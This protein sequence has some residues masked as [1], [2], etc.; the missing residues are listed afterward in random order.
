M[1]DKLFFEVL[2]SVLAVLVLVVPPCLIMR[3]K[4]GNKHLR[5]LLY[6]L[7]VVWGCRFAVGIQADFHE[8]K[9]TVAETLFDSL[10][11]AIQTFGMDD[12]YTLYTVA[13]KEYLL[14]GGFP[15]LASVYGIVM[16]VL[17]IFAPIL[18]GA[19]LLDILLGVLPELRLRFSSRRH[20]FVFSE[21]NDESITLAEDI[22][23][24]QNYRNLI[25]MGRFD[26]KPAIL[27][28]D[29]YCDDDSESSAELHSRAG[30]IGA[31]CV[32]KDLLHI[33]LKRSKSVNYFLIDVDAHANI[34]TLS[35]LLEG[36]EDGTR[37]W[38]VDPSR[39]EP[40]SRIFVF[41]QDDSG[42]ALIKRICEDHKAAA[43]QILIRQVPDQMNA[44][45][46]LMYEVP[47][48]LPL[49]FKSGDQKR[50]LHI[51]I[52]GSGPLAEETFKAA[53]WCGQMA[54][55][56]V[57]M[58]VLDRNASAMEQRVRDIYPE[59][60]ESCRS[61][62]P[63]LRVRPFDE[64]G[65]YNPPYFETAEFLDMAGMDCVSGYPAAVLENTDYY[66]V[67]LET[68]EQNLL[69]ANQLKLHAARRAMD[70]GSPV[71]PV[72]APAVE[73]QRLARAAQ[74]LK[75]G[76]YEPYFVPF[77]SLES[78]YSCKNVFLTSF[79]EQTVSIKSIYRKENQK[80]DQDDGYTNQ[81]S[82]ARAVHAPYKL[83]GL[84]L[85]RQVDL[86]KDI[87]LRY[88]VE[89][90]V[91]LTPEQEHQFAWVEHRRWNAFIRSQGFICPT[92]EQYDRFFA[93]WHETK[94]IG[95]KLHPCLVE[96]QLIPEPLPDG[97]DFDRSRYD[98]L[99]YVSMYTYSLKTRQAGKAETAA[100]L[101]DA[102][103]KKWDYRKYDAAVDALLK[104]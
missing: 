5:L 32:K 18:G 56:R 75:P 92:R 10:L 65:G 23:R 8:G 38:P 51:T 71:H 37:L 73:D 40:I 77:A 104:N 94:S 2:V 87:D 98:Y 101:A 57:H 16:S 1:P 61:G 89:G 93:L 47:L 76:A 81:S 36:R 15:W 78:R 41:R 67:A 17:N 53:Y 50:E 95:L 103:Y 24:D 6:V 79:T 27:F 20:K 21:L 102:D 49:L 26:R 54:D 12:D 82:A 45:I 83:F 62:S 7:L 88:R 60:L 11:H 48:F 28:A 85:I 70:S 100:G 33:S 58:H 29:A 4:T 22:C 25:P 59:L 90:P 72:I 84:G 55:V 86:E 46:N 68:D 34:S 42:K 97:P 9:L 44:A 69:I 3:R 64:R 35:Q 66:I 99:D 43:D 91:Q 80:K 74:V 63:L 30:D 19:L 52:L 39:E 31:I 13:G 96:S 14:S